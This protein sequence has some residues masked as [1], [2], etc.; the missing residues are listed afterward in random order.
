MV[1]PTW[2]SS[3]SDLT[4]GLP[5]VVTVQRLA[6]IMTP[7]AIQDLP[8]L[9]RLYIEHAFDGDE[10]AS[11]REVL[12]QAYAMR[13]LRLLLDGVDEAAGLRGVVERWVHEVPLLP[14]LPPQPRSP[15]SGTHLILTLAP[16]CACRC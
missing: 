12:L 16:L 9:L 5:F 4:G 2:L 15:L 6:R 8:G 10:H 3:T 11:T 14:P 7:D 13:E 1:M